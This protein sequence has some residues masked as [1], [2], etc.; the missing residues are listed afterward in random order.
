[1][2]AFALCLLFVSIDHPTP[3]PRIGIRAFKEERQMEIWGADSDDG[4][5]RLIAKYPIAAISGFLGPK[6]Q[7]G[8]LQA[9]EGFYYINRFNPNSQFHL[10]LGLNYPNSSDRILGKAGHLGRDIFIHGNQVSAGCLAMTDPVIDVIYSLARHARE[11]GQRNIP[12]SIFP[13]R[14]T[15]T[16][17]EWL[18]RE[19]ANRPDLIRFWTT[20]V[21]AYGSFERTHKWPRPHVDKGGDYI[22][23]QL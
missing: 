9:P 1:M 17:W 19:Y 6:R 12:V 22:W 3:A 4:K 13:C 11:H 18:R 8:D 7:E 23:P 5:F 16:N 21:P 20:L 10:S 2:P 15:A 14:L